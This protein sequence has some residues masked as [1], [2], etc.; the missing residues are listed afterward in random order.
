MKSKF[1]PRPLYII[2]FIS[3]LLAITAFSVYAQPGTDADPFISLSYLNA[4]TSLTPVSL[5]GGEELMITGGFGIVLL[6]GYA[7]LFPPDDSD[8]WI[9]DTTSGDIHTG[10]V[11]MSEGHMYVVVSENEGADFVLQARQESI[12]AIPGGSGR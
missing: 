10:D 1:N 3:A 4:A 2:L 9:I 5:E 12:V 8:S 11:D 6:E 7:K